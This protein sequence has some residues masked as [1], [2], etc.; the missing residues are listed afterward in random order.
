MLAKK[1]DLDILLNAR[2]SLCISIYLP[3]QGN[4]PQQN[5]IRARNLIRKAELEA[6]RLT[7]STDAH[8]LLHLLEPMLISQS[9]EASGATRG[10]AAFSCAFSQR[11]LALP[12]EFAE[13]V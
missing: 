7:C 10:L 12:L 5:A 11:V 6:A 8:D 9:Q 2:G 3:V 1:N 4:S 13:R